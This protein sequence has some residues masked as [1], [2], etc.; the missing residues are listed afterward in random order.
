MIS[1][2][3]HHNG[4]NDNEVGFVNGEALQSVGAQPATAI[5]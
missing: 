1:A 4:S 2:K 5:S 3:E